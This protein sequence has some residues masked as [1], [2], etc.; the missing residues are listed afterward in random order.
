M[1]LSAGLHLR[2]VTTMMMSTITTIIITER[3]ADSGPLGQATA[4]WERP[5]DGGIKR[6]RFAGGGVG[7]NACSGTHS[8]FPG[9]AHV[10]WANSSMRI[11]Y[12]EDKKVSH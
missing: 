1:T 2:A 5:C 10:N 6:T 11:C 8:T 12:K 4:G 7:W 3:S 9:H